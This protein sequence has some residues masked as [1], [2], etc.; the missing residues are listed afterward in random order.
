M[1]AFFS[2]IAPELWA[3]D[4]IWLPG[5]VGKW[6]QRARFSFSDFCRC[7][8]IVPLTLFN[9]SFGD[10]YVSFNQDIGLQQY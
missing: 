2:Q 5:T 4:E 7:L 9:S 1:L 6:G 8:Q 3:K 10:H